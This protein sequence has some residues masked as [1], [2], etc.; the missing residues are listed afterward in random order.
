ME[1]IIP[2]LHKTFKNIQKQGTLPNSFIEA[3]IIV[4]TKNRSRYT[5]TTHQY[6]SLTDTKNP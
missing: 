6:P 3:S 5:K 4:I 2:I 1:E